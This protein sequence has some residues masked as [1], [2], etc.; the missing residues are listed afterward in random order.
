MG[1]YRGLSNT[2]HPVDLELGPG[3]DLFSVDV[4]GTIRRIQYG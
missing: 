1:T 2:A 3:G 4:G